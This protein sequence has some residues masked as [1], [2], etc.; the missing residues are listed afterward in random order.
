[1]A[2]DAE[3]EIEL[4]RLGQGGPDPAGA[5]IGA[6]R[7]E[8]ALLR[9]DQC[10]DSGPREAPLIGQLEPILA[11]EGEWPGSLPR[12]LP[13]HRADTPG[14]VH[15]HFGDVVTPGTRQLTGKTP[16]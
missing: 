12:E 13:D 6:R 15:R 2:R 10:R 9:L 3:H 11:L 14:V 8:P 5:E 1:M 7:C 16:G 4:L